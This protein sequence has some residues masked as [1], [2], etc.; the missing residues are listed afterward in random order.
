MLHTSTTSTFISSRFPASIV[1]RVND[2]ILIPLRMGCAA[3][4]FLGFIMI[5]DNKLEIIKY[6]LSDPYTQDEYNTAVDDINAALVFTCA[7]SIVTLMIFLSGVLAKFETLHFIQACL[8]I[9]GAAL[10]LKVWDDNLHLNRVWH[11]MIF[12]NLIPAVFDVCGVIYVWLERRLW[13]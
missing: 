9:G 8:H 2:S 6:S 4:H 7:F 1:C 13:I 11:S 10:L 5:A 12:F 3:V